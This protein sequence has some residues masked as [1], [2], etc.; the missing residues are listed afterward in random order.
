MKR[1]ASKRTILAQR[2]FYDLRAK[3]RILLA[4]WIPGDI[5]DPNTVQNIT[6]VMAG[7]GAMQVEY[8]GEWK[9][10]YPYGWNSSKVGNVL[11]MCYKDTGEVRSYRLDR[12]TNIQFDDSTI[13]P[14]MLGTGDESGD[15]SMEN[16]Q[17]EEDGVEVP[18][19]PEEEQQP[20]DDSNQQQE[21]PFDDAI[22]A[23][24]DYDPAPMDNFD[25]NAE[26]LTEEDQ[27]NPELDNLNEEEQNQQVV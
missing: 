2:I 1:L 7:G 4:E 22:D 11:L 23:L 25:P 8:N 20:I 10:I 9:T 15:V 27:N 12:I 26:N 14:T 13:D 24:N 16:S 5:N 6:D 19:L 18:T 17:F 3:R 21:L